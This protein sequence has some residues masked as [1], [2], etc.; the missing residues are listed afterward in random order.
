[1]D[2]A[3]SRTLIFRGWSIVSGFVSVALVPIFLTKEEQGYYF[4]FASILAIQI[5]FELGLSQV[6]VY[7]FACIGFYE[8]GDDSIKSVNQRKLLYGAR[9]LYRLLAFI[10]FIVASTVGYQFFSTRPAGSVSWLL[11]WIVLVATTS[12]NLAQSVKLAYVEGV[13]ELAQVS[14]ARLRSSI[15]GTGIFIILLITG[16]RLWAACAIP[17]VNAVFL[18]IWINT[19]PASSFY[20]ISRANAKAPFLEV[21]SVW[22][23]EIFPMQWRISL[24]WMS[25]YF[26]F[27]LYTPIAFAKFGPVVAGKL[28]LVVSIMSSLVVVATTFTSSLSPRLARLHAAGDTG[29]F[30]RTFDT[31]I[32]QSFICL[33]ALT[34]SAT[35]LLLLLFYSSSQ[36]SNRFL[37]P[38]NT[39]IYSL[40]AILLG[41]V[42]CMSIYLR[43]QQKEP[44]F[45]HSLITAVAMIPALWIGSSASLTVMIMASL[46]VTCASSIC[47]LL[48]YL[49]NRRSLVSS[50]H[51]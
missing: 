21:F 22:R 18:A 40:G 30:N 31:S 17:I 16:G 35:L 15:V 14:L 29:M 47:V 43:S 42:S 10:F 44:L 6:L 1:M 23:R 20:R 28:G 38:F 5:F 32:R 19:H 26:I 37:D 4:A 34:Q 48:V 39:W 24:S 51:L 45:F 33:V 36:I 8:S 7:R 41:V 12:I 49:A 2:K 50:V 46:I 27:Q 9:L 11:P 3:V 25:G 13:G